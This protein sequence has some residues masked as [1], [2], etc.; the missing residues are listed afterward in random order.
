MRSALSGVGSQ[1]TAGGASH[2]IQLPGQFRTS[3]TAGM[4]EGSNHLRDDFAPSNE[5]T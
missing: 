2:A 1:K 5:E 4:V 3:N